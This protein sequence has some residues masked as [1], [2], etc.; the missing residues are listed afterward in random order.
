V[1]IKVKEREL[2]QRALKH[3]CIPSMYWDQLSFEQLGWLEE[4]TRH[5]YWDYS[6]SPRDG[7]LTAKGRVA[8]LKN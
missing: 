1:K 6:V 3:G 2:R 8:F 4:W 5:G 7:K